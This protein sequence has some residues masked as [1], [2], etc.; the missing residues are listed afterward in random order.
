MPFTPMQRGRHSRTSAGI[1]RSAV[2]PVSANRSGYHATI[3]R[4]SSDKRIYGMYPCERDVYR[5]PS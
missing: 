3:N 5:D 4:L 1:I 2:L